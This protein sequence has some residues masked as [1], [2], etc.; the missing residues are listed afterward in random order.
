MSVLVGRATFAATATA[1]AT[2][3][4]VHN[5]MQR[6]GESAR[7]CPCHGGDLSS[8]FPS[9]FVPH[10]ADC[11]KGH[12]HM[13]GKGRYAST[14]APKD[15]DY[16]FE[17][18]ASSIRYGN[19]V[20]AEVGLDCRNLR[21]KK[22]AVFTDANI[23]QL[24]PF[25]KVVASLT[26]A[27]VPHVVFSGV[28]VEPTDQSLT[29]AIEFARRQ[30]PDVFVAVGGGSTIDTAKAANLYLAHPDA[31]LLDFVN[32][33]IGKGLP[34]RRAL[35]P[36][37]AIPTT[38]GTGSETTGV[39]IFDYTPMNYKTGIAS[40]AL[41]PTLGIIDPENTRSMPPNV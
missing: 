33:P 39:A 16:A 14:S 41:K 29:A 35:S 15:T 27:G 17:M 1:T 40:R 30:Q 26:A 36:L 8:R 10:S 37:I 28:Q 25:K 5:V 38:A 31:A 2:R 19:G 3:S 12:S 34:V 24:A 4:G 18:A 22:V 20:T 7:G 21:A 6:V 11:T 13:G 9:V 32:A 23:A